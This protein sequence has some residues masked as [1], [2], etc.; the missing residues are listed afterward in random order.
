MVWV[1]Y[2]SHARSFI[3]FTALCESRSLFT[4]PHPPTKLQPQFIHPP[5]CTP[6][7]L[8]H[9]HPNS[10]GPAQCVTPLARF[11]PAATS[12]TAAMN[13]ALDSYFAQ[14]P[15]F[16][17]GECKQYF[18]AGNEH[19]AFDGSG[20]SSGNAGGSF[21][22]WDVFRVGRSGGGGGG[23]S[24][25]PA[26]T[27]PAASRPAAAAAAGGGGSISRPTAAPTPKRRRLV[28]ATA[29]TADPSHSDQQLPQYPPVFHAAVE[30]FAQKASGEEAAAWEE[31]GRWVQENREMMH[32][33]H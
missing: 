26:A 6:P 4:L 18:D 16:R 14:L 19:G 2:M 24:G 23:G 29:A 22:F 21:S 27:T 7:L 15:K 8:T 30:R 31:L 3:R 13:P 17:W 12:L 10:Q 9:P 25:G 28:E 32:A 5:H 1:I 20:S 33:F 11:K